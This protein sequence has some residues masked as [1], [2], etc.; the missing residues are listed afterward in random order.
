MSTGEGHILAF[1]TGQDEIEKAC[2]MIKRAAEED[3]IKGVQHQ[4]RFPSK[5]KKA[6]CPS[7]AHTRTHAQHRRP[8]LPT[9]PQQ[10]AEMDLLVLPLYGALT[11]EQQIQVFRSV[12]P[13]VRKC[14]VATNIAETSV[15]VPGVRC[16]RVRAW[17][18]LCVCCVS[19]PEFWDVHWSHSGYA[20]LRQH[21]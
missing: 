7:P 4:V 8:F 6:Y 10:Q 5:K 20:P 15:T 16:V 1:L 18:V 11:A 12:P 19:R 9:Q 13:H 14:I 17:C 3:R 21:I 2:N